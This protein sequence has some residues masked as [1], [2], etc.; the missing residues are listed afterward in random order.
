MLLT[1]A[2]LHTGCAAMEGVCEQECD[3]TYLWMEK[4][5]R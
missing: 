4:N 2:P 5:G 3:A 1:Q